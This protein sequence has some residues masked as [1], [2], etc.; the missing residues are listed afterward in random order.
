MLLTLIKENAYLLETLYGAFIMTSLTKALAD[1]RQAWEAHPEAK[2]AWCLHHELRLEPLTAPYEARITYIL[3]YKPKDEQ[4]TRLNNFRPV[5]SKLPA[6]IIKQGKAY[7]KAWEARDKAWEAH[8][9][10]WEARDKAWEACGKAREAYIEAGKARDKAW[11]AYDKA[12]EACGETW[13]AYDKAREAYIEVGKAYREA[14][15]ANTT[16]LQALH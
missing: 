7:Y 16:K 9:E 14:I 12:L 2:W 15:P 8:V 10:A 6:K 13:E 5:L 3:K 11:D 4:T 1:C